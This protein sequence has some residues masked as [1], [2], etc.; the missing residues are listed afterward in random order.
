MKHIALGIAVFIVLLISLSFGE[1][2]GLELFSWLSY[3]F[4]YVS[5]HL[6]DISLKLQGYLNL[7]WGKVLL[8]LALT[9]PISYWLSKKNRDQDSHLNKKTS[10]R[11]IAIFLAIFLG[12]LGIHRF[13][14]GQLGWGLGYL[15]LFYLFAPLAILLGWIDALRYV[16]MSDDEFA[17][18]T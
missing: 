8:A 13:Y 16:L 1:R 6:Q 10:R 17:L 4:G 18:I 11:K 3:L 15:V 9:L 12:W 2:I 14:I 5:T 7:N